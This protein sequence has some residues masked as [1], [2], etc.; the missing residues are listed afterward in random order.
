MV[1]ES[2][3]A[4]L[5]GRKAAGH[6]MPLGNAAGAAVATPATHTNE[7]TRVPTGPKG[8][9][10]VVNPTVSIVPTGADSRVGSA[11]RNAVEMAERGFF[12]FPL[13]P[14]DKRPAIPDWEHRAT[15]NAAYVASHWP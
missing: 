1:T 13:R 9:G 4:A 7:N 14:D 15:S 8:S 2:L 3:E 10:S 11:A 12:V 6:R 5:S